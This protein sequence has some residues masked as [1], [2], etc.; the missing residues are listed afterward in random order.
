VIDT[1]ASQSVVVSSLVS[2]LKLPSAGPAQDFEGVGCSGSAEPRQVNS[3]S[4]AGLTLAGQTVSGAT[5][6]GMG[7]AGQPDGLLGSDVLSRFGAARIDFGASTITVPGPEGP[8][9][10]VPSTVK[11]PTAIP[12]PQVLLTGTSSGTVPLTVDGGPGLSEVIAPVHLADHS[13]LPFAVDT[14]SSQSVVSQ[15]VAHNLSLAGTTTL[16]RQ[17]TVCST[18]T[19]PLVRSGTWSVGAVPLVTGHIA[20]ANLGPVASAGFVG[21]LGSDQLIH[22]GWVVFD[23]RGARLVLGST[24]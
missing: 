24:S 5:L 9:P 16:E 10:S 4:L 18:I 23:Y 2:S 14:G 20:T 19:V 15:S 21:L 22:F 1:G 7:A 17:T 8:A 6:P 12:T 11:G 13:A 3:W